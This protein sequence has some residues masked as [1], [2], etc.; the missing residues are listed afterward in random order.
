VDFAPGTT[1]S[2]N[3]GAIA[4]PV[5]GEGIRSGGIQVERPVVVLDLPEVYVI[6]RQVPVKK[7]QHTTTLAVR[8]ID[9]IPFRVPRLDEVARVA[10]GINDRG[11]EREREYPGAEQKIP[12]VPSEVVSANH[13]CC[14]TVSV[15][16]ALGYL[17][18]V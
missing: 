8:S 1:G 13:C 11:S 6:D 14:H 16:L 12:D 7:L 17:V 9:V 15:L 5:H 18:G 4:G 2:G 10:I 3:D